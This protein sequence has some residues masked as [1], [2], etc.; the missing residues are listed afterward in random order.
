MATFK[1]D[2]QALAD[3]H[4]KKDLEE[5]RE[6]TDRAMRETA[7]LFLRVY[8]DTFQLDDEGD[9]DYDKIDQSHLRRAGRLRDALRGLLPKQDD[10]EESQNEDSPAAEQTTTDPAAHVPA[11]RKPDGEPKKFRRLVRSLFELNGEK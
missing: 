8:R 1:L 5:L 2:L 10:A 6:V 11:Q 4:D 7:S 9:P 3:E